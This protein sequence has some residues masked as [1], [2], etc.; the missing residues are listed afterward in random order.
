MVGNQFE[1]LNHLAMDLS[2]DSSG[3]WYYVCYF[4]TIVKFITSNEQVHFDCLSFIAYFCYFMM[5]FSV[6]W[7]L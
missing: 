3:R 7:K 6:A 2:I 5:D 4:K 1:F